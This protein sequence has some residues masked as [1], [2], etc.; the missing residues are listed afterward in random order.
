MCK[1]FAYRCASPHAVGLV[2]RI[3]TN[4]I[5]L[6]RRLAERLMHRRTV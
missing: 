3:E 5:A 4:I 6:Y 2:V 1:V